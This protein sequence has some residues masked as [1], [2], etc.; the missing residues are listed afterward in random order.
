MS[1]YH[2]HIC[3]ACGAEARTYSDREC[4]GL[5]SGW[6]VGQ[7]GAYCDDCGAANAVLSASLANPISHSGDSSRLSE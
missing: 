5:P 1:G 4:N 7:K 6:A 3:D 2:V